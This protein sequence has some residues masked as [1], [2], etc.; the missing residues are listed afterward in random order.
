[1]A[2]WKHSSESIGEI[3][4]GYDWTNKNG[5]FK[6]SISGKF[7]KEL[8]PVFKEELDFFGFDNK[9]SYP[10]TEKPLLWAEDGRRYSLNGEHVAEA[11]GGGFYTKP[12]IEYKQEKLALAPI[13]IFELSNENFDVM[14]GLEQ[15]AILSIRKN[16]ERFKHQGYQFVCAF[17]GGKDSLVL[18]D[19]VSKALTPD[20]F[21]V[22]FSNTGMELSCTYATIE[23]AK[24]RYTNLRFY[25]AACHLP[26]EKTWEEFGPPGRRMRWCCAVHKSVPTILKIRELAEDYNARAVVFDGVRAEESA[27]RA[28][29]EEISIGAKNTSQIN[30]S[31]ILKWNSAEI[32]LYLLANDL[33]LNSAYKAG[34]FRVGCKICPMSSNWWDGIA[35]DIYGSELAS[36]FEK[37]EEYGRNTKPE[38]EVTRFIEDGGWKARMGGR[39]LPNGGNRITETV[40]NDEISFSFSV[41]TNKWQTVAPILGKIVAQNEFG[42]SQIIDGK[43]LT[44]RIETLCESAE[45]ITYKP[46]SLLDRFEVSR[47]RGTA[48]KAAYCCGCKACMVQCP[49]GAYVIN[50]DGK[51]FIRESKCIHCAKCISFCGKGCL[52]A[53]SL[54]VTGGSYMDL[55]GINRYQHFGLRKAFLEHFFDLKSACFS[56]GRLGN[57][58]YDALK[59]WL[60]ECGLLSTAN[61]G[62]KVG[63]PTELFD[64]LVDVGLGASDYLTWAAIWTNLAYNSKIVKWYMMFVPTGSTYEKGDLVYMLGD[65][66]SESTRDNAV[67]A[68]LET[69]RDSPTGDALKQGIPIKIGSVQKYVKTGWEKPD[70]V[71]LLYALYR[72]AEET[73]H[74]G[75]SVSQLAEARKSGDA[76]GMDPIAIFGIQPEIFKDILRELAIH[77]ED[78]IKVSF[79]AGLDSVKLYD[80]IKSLDVFSIVHQ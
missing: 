50:D 17:S 14:K 74:Y 72:F 41:Q 68:L 12:T 76:K 49:T 2:E 58:Q 53:K 39:G 4:Y 37:V 31:P 3:M 46:Y 60:R 69:L 20:E 55:T 43:T 44:C 75:F 11:H 1:M 67:T 36:L 5:I 26:P 33:M 78:Y 64:K 61:R 45:K 34:L 25:E 24:A 35:N 16:Y 21:Y 19:L 54:S 77:F 47:L 29:Y 70:S 38:K 51:I 80:N 6:L 56:S 15:T 65:E 52:V 22:I 8:R 40:D 18:L 13:D 30:C 23:K 32:F 63:Q 7:E 48:N 73:G 62:E 28:G 10:E 57:R 59:V 66:F 9:W 71:A 27:Q 79:Q 42:F